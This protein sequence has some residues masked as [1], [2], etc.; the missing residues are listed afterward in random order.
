MTIS[1]FIAESLA[2]FSIFAMIYAWMLLGTALQ[3]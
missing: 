1:R 3:S 2:L